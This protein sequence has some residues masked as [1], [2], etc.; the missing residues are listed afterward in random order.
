[1]RCTFDML[2]DLQLYADSIVL[3]TQQ[4]DLKVS[5]TS[6]VK[7]GVYPAKEGA[8]CDPNIAQSFW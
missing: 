6:D 2:L 1:M 4:V 3:N 8:H 5:S 7:F